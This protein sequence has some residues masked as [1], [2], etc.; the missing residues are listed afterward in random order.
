MDWVVIEDPVRLDDAHYSVAALEFGEWARRARGQGVSRA[1]LPA[2]YEEVLQEWSLRMD[3]RYETF[4]YANE[5]VVSSVVD[6]PE[7]E[8]R[9]DGNDY[10]VYL[11]HY[12]GLRDRRRFNDMYARREAGEEI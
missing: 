9:E 3:P 8:D 6:H 11:V 5:D 4:I 12:E 1:D 2:F 7:G 10:F